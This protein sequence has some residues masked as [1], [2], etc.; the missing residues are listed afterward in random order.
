MIVLL[1]SRDSFDTMENIYSSLFPLITSG[2]KLYSDIYYIYILYGKIVRIDIALV[3]ESR[4]TVN[5]EPVIADT[6]WKITDYLSEL[7]T[8][9][10]TAGVYSPI[11]TDGGPTV[12]YTTVVYPQNDGAWVPQAT[13]VNVSA[14]DIVSPDV[15]DDPRFLIGFVA[16]DEATLNPNKVFVIKPLLDNTVTGYW[17]NWNIPLASGARLTDL[18]TVRI[19]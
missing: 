11:I 19:I 9:V 16:E 13:F 18:E 15:A 12:L 6:H 17:A 3:P 4:T 8:V 2:I 10:G 5:I 14:A 1:E 7:G